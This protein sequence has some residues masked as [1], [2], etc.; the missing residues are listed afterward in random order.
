MPSD[1]NKE[2]FNELADALLGRAPAQDESDIGSVFDSRLQQCRI[3]SQAG[4]GAEALDCLASN[5]YEFE[6]PLTVDEV[7]VIERLA[8]AWGLARDKWSFIGELVL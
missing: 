5:L 1:I 6:V 8:A 3:M 7:E 2:T 4:E